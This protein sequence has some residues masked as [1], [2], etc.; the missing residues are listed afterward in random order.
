[1]IISFSGAPGSGKS[2]IAKMLA[3][4]LDWPR[5]YIGGLRRQKAKER[6]MTLEEYNRLGE[7]DPSTDLEVDEYQEKLGQEQDNFIIEGRTSWY[8]IPHS[9]KIYLDVHPRK[10]AERIYKALQDKN[11]KRNESGAPASIEEV[12]KSLENRIKSDNKRYKKYFG[13]NAYDKNN[14][15]IVVDTTDLSPEEAFIKVYE[16]VKKRKERA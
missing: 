8:F 16:Q 12:E 11:D 14:Y 6:G 1:M 10:G 4:E 15:D 5:Y 9:L 7:K 2:T 13:I 3:Q